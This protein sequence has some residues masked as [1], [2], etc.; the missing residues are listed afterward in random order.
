MRSLFKEN[1][2]KINAL[3]IIFALI[4]V[5]ILTVIYSTIIFFEYLGFQNFILKIYEN[6]ED[7][8]YEYKS[9]GYLE[10]TNFCKIWI[11]RCQKYINEFSENISNYINNLSK[12]NREI[13][14]N[15]IKFYL[16]SDTG[17]DCFLNIRN[18]H[19]YFYIRECYFLSEIV[20]RLLKN[21]FQN[22]ITVL[23]SL[24]K[25][26]T[27]EA[28]EDYDKVISSNVYN[29]ICNK[30]VEEYRHTAL[31]Y[32]SMGGA[33]GEKEYYIEKVAKKKDKNYY[34]IYVRRGSK[35]PPFF[36]VPYIDE[37]EIISFFKSKLGL[38]AVGCFSTVGILKIHNV[39][40]GSEFIVIYEESSKLLECYH[41]KF[42]SDSPP[43]I[44]GSS[45][46][47]NKC[48]INYV[49]SLFSS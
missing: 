24:I 16:F 22:N 1:K 47:K 35:L 26:I 31:I 39:S 5:I 27:E 17:Y 45:G 20:T 2:S 14:K 44:Y 10:W 38:I 3:I 41:H 46:E 48:D 8:N 6:F 30:D 33:C 43:I 19:L 4:L 34:I 28:I 42:S 40:Y 32:L 9:F 11:T 36:K 23:C 49:L 29:K 15:I 12:N 21:K 25:E 37:K 18:D 13:V 7:V